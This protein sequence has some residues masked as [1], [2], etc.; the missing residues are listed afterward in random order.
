MALLLIIVL[1][2]LAILGFILLSCALDNRDSLGLICSIGVSLMAG[3]ATLPALALHTEPT[4]QADR[5]I[6][7]RVEVITNVQAGDTISIDTIW[8]YKLVD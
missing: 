6:K 3:M 5:E 4:L 7:P 1:V 8:H 2:L